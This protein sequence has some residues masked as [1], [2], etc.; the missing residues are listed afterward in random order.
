[1]VETEENRKSKSQEADKTLYFEL[2]STVY[3]S[4]RRYN[5]RQ[6]STKLFAEPFH[7]EIGHASHIADYNE[8]P[9]W[10]EKCRYEHSR[11]ANPIERSAT[12]LDSATTV[13][14]AL[15]TCIPAII[16]ST[17]FLAAA[18]TAATI[19]ISYLPP[20]ANT[21][22]QQQTWSTTSARTGPVL[23]PLLVIFPRDNLSQDA[24]PRDNCVPTPFSSHSPSSSL[25]KEPIP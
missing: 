10:N 3:S 23:P 24:C 11:G 2:F 9:K 17:Y 18:L 20:T 12:G 22:V 15:T 1:M 13:P 21:M 6:L 7:P 5:A 4:R 19:F 25:V 14:T 8:D 16:L